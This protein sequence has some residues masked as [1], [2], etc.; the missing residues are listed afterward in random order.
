M[1]FEA[2][3]KPA[4]SVSCTISLALPAATASGFISASVCS[5]GASIATSAIAKTRY[6]QHAFGM[7]ILPAFLLTF[8]FHFPQLTSVQ[9]RAGSCSTCSQCTYDAILDIN[10]AFLF[11]SPYELPGERG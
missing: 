11:C 10:L 4:F 7:Q 3:V 8:A 6:S 5:T 1:R 9:A 2:I